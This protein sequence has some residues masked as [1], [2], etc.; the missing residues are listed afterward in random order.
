MLVLDGVG[1]TDGV[2]VVAG[3]GSGGGVA[4]AYDG[5]CIAVGEGGV[6]MVHALIEDRSITAK[7][8]RL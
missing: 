7:T 2:W 8:A 3:G 5:V 4:D 6:R 1:V